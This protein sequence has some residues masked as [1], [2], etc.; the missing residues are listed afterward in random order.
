[1]SRIDRQLLTRY[2]LCIGLLAISMVAFPLL[3]LAVHSLQRVAL[4]ALLAN[5]LFFWPQYLLLPNGLVDL[6]T[7]AQHL[8]S[9]AVYG[10]V[11]FWLVVV[12]AHVWATRKLRLA[13]VLVGLLPA[14]G[15]VAQLVSVALGELGFAISLD[16]P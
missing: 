6:A 14:V 4:P 5:L 10:A 2:V 3:V 7:D 16:G 15:V 8:P 9:L 1:M 13:W 12:A 11:A